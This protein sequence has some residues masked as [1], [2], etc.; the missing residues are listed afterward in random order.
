MGRPYG[1]LRVGFPY[2]KT[3]GMRRVTNFPVDVAI[4]PDGTIY[5]LCWSAGAAQISRLNFDGDDL[6]PISG[7][8]TDD[9]KLQA[10]A[11]IAVDRD[12]NLFVSDSGLNRVTILDK[13]GKFLEKWGERGAGEGQLDRP[14]G[15]AFDLEGNLCIVDTFNHRVQRFS[16]D[17]H[18]LS[19][20]GREGGG[21]GELSHPWGIA[22]D[23]LGDVYVAD[24]RNDRIQQ[25]DADG[26]FKRR[27][28][29]P[30][31]GDGELNRPAGVAVDRDGDVYVADTGNNRVQLFNAEGRYVEKF[32]GD[33]TL[34]RSGRNYML[35]NARPNRLRDMANL[36][37]QKRFRSPKAVRVDDQ[38]RMYVPDYGAYRV[39]IYQK[40]VVALRPDQMVPPL[41]SPSLQT[42]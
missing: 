42:T 17:G 25:F 32:V 41:R 26:R 20:W 23:E 28:G 6:G 9:G 5:V 22:V 37:P 36:E 39:Q 1:L 31:S 21:D 4:G 30:G 35:T 16:R 2:V 19:A 11:S 10:P 33:A 3:I 15:L 34:S 14:S 18:F 7:Y 12:G 38:G 27:I 40:E 24:W 13:E 8:G 29:R